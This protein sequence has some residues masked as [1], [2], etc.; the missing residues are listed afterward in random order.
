MIHKFIDL[1]KTQYWVQD[2]V[3]Y[4]NK[5]WNLNPLYHQVLRVMK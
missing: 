1:T 4:V 2:V 5:W 3:D